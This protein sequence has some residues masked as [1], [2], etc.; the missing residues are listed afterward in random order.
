MQTIDVSNFNSQSDMPETRAK[1]DAFAKLIPNEYRFIKDV[2][3]LQ[4]QGMKH[5]TKDL[6]KL[7]ETY[8]QGHERKTLSKYDFTAKLREIKLDYKDT[9]ING[10]YYYRYS[11]EQ[12]KAIADKFHW[13][14]ELDEAEEDDKKQVKEKAPNHN[15]F[16]K[17]ENDQLKKQIEV[18]QQ[19]IKDLTAKKDVK[20]VIKKVVRKQ[21]KPQPEPESEPEEEPVQEPVLNSQVRPE[22]KH[23]RIFGGSA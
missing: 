10:F 14:H 7:Y 20:K 21:P 15:L 16:L 3:I 23:L 13:I 1:L 5:S 17:S 18:L 12:L 19:Q 2:F 6:Y 11:Y 8:C 4:N 22:D 9:K